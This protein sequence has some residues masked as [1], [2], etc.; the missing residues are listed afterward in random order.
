MAQ[1]ATKTQLK[2]PETGT[3]REQRPADR[4][5]WSDCLKEAV[6]RATDYLLSLQ[7]DP[8][9]WIGELEADS[10]LESDYI[11][12]L[13][14]TGT[15][16]A[17]H[18]A[19][20]AHTLRREQLA[21]GGWNIYAGGPP[22]LNAT[23]KG[24][25][26]LKLAGDSPEA[27]HMAAA[28]RTA[29]ELGGL[30]KTNS[31]VR[32]Y[33]ALAGKVAWD[34]VPAM[35]PELILLPRWFFVN[36]YEMSSWTRG[37]VVP[38]T[39]LFALR[40]NWRLPES[41]GVD[42]LWKDPRRKIP[43]LKWDRQIVSW[44][45]FFI[46][47]DR[48]FKAYEA[49]PWK[50]PRRAALARSRHWLLDHLERSDGLAA[51]YP[52]MLNSVL[53]LIALGYPP[54]HPLTARE[55]GYL[56]EF[57]IEEDDSIRIQPCLPPVW[58]TAL[59]MAALEEANTPPD[60]P[61]L[62]LA[63]RWLLEKQVMGSGDWQVKNPGACPAGWAFEFRNDFYPDVDD[64]AFVLMSLQN[65][66]YPDGAR[67]Q[68]ALEKGLEWVL[69]MQNRDG[70]WGAFDKNN[71]HSLLTRVPFADHNAMI[72]PSTPDLTARALECLGRFG[73]SPSQRAVRKAVEY[74][75][76]QQTPEGAWYGRWGVNYIYGTSGVLRALE[77]V[78]LQK[79]EF[80]QR[81]AAWLRSVQ[82]RDGGFGESIA[83]YDDPSLKGKGEST[84]SQTAWGMI[85]LLTAGAP[86]DSA[87]QRAAHYLV[88]RQNA[89][90]SWDEDQ[91]TGTGFP[92][93]FYLKYHLYRIS[94]P[95]YALARYYNLTKR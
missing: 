25:F 72:D 78:G 6:S 65:V 70:G 46:L 17:A 95:L 16:S 67:H 79:E 73:M 9:Y 90:G 75:K 88:D 94:F 89:D 57:E 56:S 5:A 10:T 44:H 27:P 71:T 35:P 4:R 8:G 39:I 38:L 37:I 92:Q 29:L 13:H 60:H 55:R 12:A 58:D 80:A 49:L 15:S 20:L 53:A 81:A 87:I 51:I 18:T 30:E 24:Y 74:L 42:E 41:A 36:L 86:S 11:F 43:A 40:P 85:G 54:D 32:F 45:N 69:S 91:W 84:A 23:V 28:R 26:A 83:S 21:G 77:T 66:S 93:V 59:A 33:F 61:A 76:R 31:Y 50:P 68:A 64:S 48:V 3:T 1:E 19:K 22:E 14:L 52:A 62:V 7:K 47:A 2:R 82:N 63:A 34:K